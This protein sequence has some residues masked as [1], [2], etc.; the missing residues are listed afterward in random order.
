[1]AANLATHAEHG[2]EPAA[3][4]DFD[5]P[6]QKGWAFFTK[7]LLWNIISCTAI[8]LLIGLLTVWS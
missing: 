1:M 3:N 4:V 7:F 2:T 6:A 8:L 5:A